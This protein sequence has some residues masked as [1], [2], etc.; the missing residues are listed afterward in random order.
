MEAQPGSQEWLAHLSERDFSNRVTGPKDANDAWNKTLVVMVQ[1]LGFLPDLSTQMYANLG[2]VCSPR[3]GES[4]VSLSTPGAVI[5]MFEGKESDMKR[6]HSALMMLRDQGGEVVREVIGDLIVWLEEMSESI[7]FVEVEGEATI[8]DSAALACVTNGSWA[9][10]M[11]ELDES[12][13]REVEPGLVV[14]PYAP[15]VVLVEE[16]ATPRITIAEVVAPRTPVG[17]EV[18]G[19]VLGENALPPQSLELTPLQVAEMFGDDTVEPHE[20][21]RGEGAS[22]TATMHEIRQMAQ[23]FGRVVRTQAEVRASIIHAFGGG[24]A[25]ENMFV[26]RTVLPASVEDAPPTGTG[27]ST[28]QTFRDNAL[29]FEHL[30]RGVNSVGYIHTHYRV[31]TGLLGIARLLARRNREAA[32]MF[33]SYLAGLYNDVSLFAPRIPDHATNTRYTLT[34][35]PSM[36]SLHV[37]YSTEDDALYRVWALPAS[38]LSPYYRG[39]FRCLSDDISSHE[40]VN[41]TGLSTAW[42]AGDALVLS[43]EVMFDGITDTPVFD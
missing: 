25:A 36:T 10:T 42:S 18:E 41:A 35:T 34:L 13:L 1:G 30:Y 9:V 2:V 6:V 20:S 37:E 26:P 12:T 28:P 27:D 15:N 29:V 16:P 24:E 23:E 40:F 31:E 39:L 21:S 4:F 32:A 43:G 5:E 33:C 19:T 38:P 8:V 22:D 3:K 7:K 14:E 11:E 17:D